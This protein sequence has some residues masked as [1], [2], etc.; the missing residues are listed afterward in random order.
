MSRA[1]KRFTDEL[2]EL[3]HLPR[4]ELLQLLKRMKDG[5]CDLDNLGT[6]TDY[7]DSS[8]HYHFDQCCC[9]D[10]FRLITALAKT[11]KLVYDAF[12]IERLHLLLKTTCTR[13]DNTRN[14]EKSA[15]RII[16]ALV[17][18]LALYRMSETQFS[19][20][21]WSM[22]V[23]EAFSSLFEELDALDHLDENFDEKLAEY[24]EAS[25]PMIKALRQFVW[26]E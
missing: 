25:I 18:L 13:V 10:E 3:A 9:S 26:N 19:A 7:Y 11:Q 20:L 6:S 8:F 5:S 23:N 17:A 16:V 22:N 2:P 15:W 12:V 24:K 14:F 4:K 21:A 1:R